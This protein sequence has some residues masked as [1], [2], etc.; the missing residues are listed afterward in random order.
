M[1]L[2]RS[3]SPSKKKSDGKSPNK[4]EKKENGKKAK[5]D[6][7][8]DNSDKKE[9]ETG[10]KGTFDKNEPI[11][12]EKKPEPEKLKEVWNTRLAALFVHDYIMH[13]TEFSV[14]KFTTR[15]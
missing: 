13:H 11:L 8:Q 4:K 6:K 5:K 1:N 15:R 10:I 14:D 7:K 3:L 12:A 2:F 9:A